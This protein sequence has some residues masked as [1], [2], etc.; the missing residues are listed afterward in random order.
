M[1]EGH[2]ASSRAD[3]VEAN[4]MEQMANS[5]DMYMK[6]VTL[7]RERTL[8]QRTIGLAQI[9]PGDRVLE[10]GCGTGTLTLAA[11]DRVGPAG[12]VCGI[13]VIPKM[14]ELSQ[15]KA[16]RAGATIGFQAGSIDNIPFPEDRFDVVLSSFMIFH[17][18]EEVRARGIREIYRVLKPRGRLL[19][20]DMALPSGPVQQRLARRLFGF[21]L[22][23]DLRELLPLL[24]GTGFT[25][26]EVGSVNFQI[27]GLS[28][29]G[30]V[31][32][33]V[34]KERAL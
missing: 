34:G 16:A 33:R 14:I 6:L 20:L 27:L 2:Q 8:R 23:H 18:P 11:R 3:Q 15:R 30:Y 19:V 25:G 13:D 9:E 4:P 7:G 29:L 5:Y 10:V 1:N 32:A 28:I 26:I 17:M 12:E 31:R 21:M 22:E 24:Q